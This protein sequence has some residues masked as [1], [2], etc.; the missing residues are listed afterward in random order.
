MLNEVLWL[1]E[2]DVISLNISMADVISAVEEGWRLKG[3]G[4]VEMPAKIGIHPREN[5]YIHAMPCWIGGGVDTCGEKWISG[6]PENLQKNMP[7]NIGLF[8]ITDSNDGHMISVMDATYLTTMRTG[9]AS[10]VIAKYFADPKSSKLAVIGAGTQGRISVHAIKTQFPALRTVAAYDPLAVQLDKLEA[11]ARAAFNDLEVVKA[12]SIEEACKDADIVI[13][14]CPVLANPQRFVKKSYLKNDVLCIAVDH[15]SAFCADVM[16]EA[17]VYVIDD[18]GQYEYMQG[19]GV[20][21]QGYPT[22]QEIYAEMSEVIVGKKPVVLKGRR[23]AAPM[24][25]ACNDVMTARL[26]YTKAVEKKV[27]TW[28]KH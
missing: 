24:G 22:E 19:G 27:G 2:D 26:I 3:E 6:F 12:K 7:Y 25:I 16:T 14:C 28:V 17:P 4:K 18:R 11:D 5:C 13:T 1:S 21:F 8:I 23:T 10:A 9:A 20:Y 15:D